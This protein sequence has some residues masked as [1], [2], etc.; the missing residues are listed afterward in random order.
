ME[1]IIENVILS[2]ILVGFFIAIVL[3]F[4]AFILDR[5]E[6]ETIDD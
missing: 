1:N 6:F 4:D 3:E 2:K 5:V